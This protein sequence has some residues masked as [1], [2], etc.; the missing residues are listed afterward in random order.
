[1]ILEGY[2]ASLDRNSGLLYCCL[3]ASADPKTWYDMNTRL[4]AIPEEVMLL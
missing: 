3:I 1:M 2:F 4:L